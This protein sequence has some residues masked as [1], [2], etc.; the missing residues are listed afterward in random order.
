MLSDLHL[1]EFKKALPELLN[2]A[3]QKQPS[4]LEFIKTCLE[5]EVAARQVKSLSARMKQARFPYE[6]VLDNFD[7]GFQTSVSKR[8]ID[9]LKEM[10]WLKD[11]YNLIFLG[12]PGIGK[13]HLAVGLG[14]EAVRLGYHAYFITL[15]ELL[16]VLKTQ[17]MLHRSQRKVKQL[18]TADLVILDEIGYGEVSKHEANLLFQFISSLYQN[19][20]VIVT[21]NKGFDEWPS[22]LGDAV[23]TTAILDRLVHKSEIFNM[24]G[25]S[26]RLQHRNT[27]F[28]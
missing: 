25:D 21:T 20:S 16:N 24:V 6:G 7:F 1:S 11:A 2:H 18:I 14:I 9:T 19:V 28:R 15:D 4:Y 22:F 13:T 8:Q 3:I 10:H 12:P 17:P 5:T 26:Y 27:I 23:I